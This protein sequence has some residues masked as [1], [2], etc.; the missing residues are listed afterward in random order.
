M[1]GPNVNLK[2]IDLLKKKLEEDIDEDTKFLDISSCG[3]HVLHG[4]FI[5][6]AKYR[7]GD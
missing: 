2:F 1:D 6:H 3:L 4:V 5:T 7:L